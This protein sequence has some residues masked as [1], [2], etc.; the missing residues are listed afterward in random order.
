MQRVFNLNLH[1]VCNNFCVHCISHNTR[2]KT[3]VSL[4]LDQVRKILSIYSPKE[5]DIIILSGGEPSMFPNLSMLLKTIRESSS[6][7]IVMYSNGAGLCTAS[8]AQ[9]VA[10]YVDRVTLSYYGDEIIHD[11]YA[12]RKGAFA[13]LKKAVEEL[14]KA[15]EYLTH[16]CALEVKY[17]RASDDIPLLPLLDGLTTPNQVE[18]VVLSRILSVEVQCNPVLQQDSAAMRDILE[19]REH[20]RWSRTILKLVDIL[21]CSLGQELFDEIQGDYPQRAVENIIFFDGMYPEGKMI[22]FSPL[23]LFDRRCSSCGLQSVCGTTAT[24]YGALRRE[25]GH[26]Y[27]AEE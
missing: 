1:Y 21:P 22:R 16:T 19:L 26:W 7:K 27:Y 3:T 4:D 10:R 17:V 13:I 24:C 9:A 23:A 8:T 6:C 20:K 12:G 14:I 15:R 25:R 11:R 2:E 18:S 5:K